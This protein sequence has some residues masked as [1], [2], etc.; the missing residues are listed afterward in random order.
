MSRS[1]TC[2]FEKGRSSGDLW[3]VWN[4]ECAN[5]FPALV[6]VSLAKAQ[7]IPGAEDGVGPWVPGTSCV[8]TAGNRFGPVGFA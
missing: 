2:G 6:M 3:L 4:S 1:H 5:L 8:S 7:N